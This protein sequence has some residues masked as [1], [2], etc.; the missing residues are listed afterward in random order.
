MWPNPQECDQ[1]RR[2]LRVSSHLL[3]KSLM[4]NFIFC[5]MTLLCTKKKGRR[6]FTTLSNI[7]D[8]AFSRKWLTYGRN[9]T[10][11]D[12]IKFVEDSLKKTLRDM[13]CYS[14]PYSF[15]F[16]K[17]CLPQI[18]LGPFL[19]TIPHI[20]YFREKASIADFWQDP[21]YAS[22]M[23]YASTFHFRSLHLQ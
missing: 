5:A 20:Y 11:M 15:K 8:R 10:R 19:N 22:Q 3:K 2:K 23:S 18:L 7:Y 21:K 9:Y 1:I 6:V 14:R 4:E 13:V 16:F 12:Q 17:G